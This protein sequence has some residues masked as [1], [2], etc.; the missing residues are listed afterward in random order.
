MRVVR[1]AQ[2]D[3]QQLAQRFVS[4]GS[5][6]MCSRVNQVSACLAA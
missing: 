2:E 4:R 1:E 5:T 3:M 6:F